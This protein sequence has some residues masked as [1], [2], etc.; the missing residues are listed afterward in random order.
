MK[1]D[2]NDRNKKWLSHTEFTITA[3]YLLWDKWTDEQKYLGS[4]DPAE[5]LSLHRP[6]TSCQNTGRADHSGRISA[7]RN[8]TKILNYHS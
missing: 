7:G 3:K 4:C 6:A 2:P 5:K 1:K 8:G